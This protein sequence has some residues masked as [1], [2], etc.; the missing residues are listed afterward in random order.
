[1]SFLPGNFADNNQNSE[2]LLIS[3]FFMIYFNILIFSKSL[4]AHNNMTDPADPIKCDQWPRVA[5]LLCY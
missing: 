5:F 2:Y 3:F 4:F 1:M